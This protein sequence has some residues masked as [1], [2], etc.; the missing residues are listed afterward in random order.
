V[1]P[2]RSHGGEARQWVV[3]LVSVTAVL[4][5]A[6]GTDMTADG[7]SGVDPEATSN[8]SSVGPTSPGPTLFLSTGRWHWETGTDPDHA[9]SGALEV[10]TPITGPGDDP[11]IVHLEAFLA[12]DQD[13]AN[14]TIRE[15]HSEM[16]TPIGSLSMQPAP[17]QA[18]P[19]AERT[20]ASWTN[21]DIR[22][23]TGC[24]HTNSNGITFVTWLANDT[25]YH[26]ATSQ[27]DI[28]TATTYLNTW[29][30]LTQD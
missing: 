5:A 13:Q 28:D 18:A 24:T 1:P 22:S 4:A 30:L 16:A 17:T 10:L 15:P 12:G 21:I 19:C 25:T 29:Q 3:L 20:D 23:T 2:P 9:Y 14:I 8:T 6:C 27:L 26:F 11:V 7:A